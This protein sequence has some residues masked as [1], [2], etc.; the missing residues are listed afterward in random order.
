MHPTFT[1]ERARH[2]RGLTR[3]RRAILRRRLVAQPPRVNVATRMPP[4]VVRRSRV[5][6][7]AAP[8]SRRSWPIEAEFVR[9][10]VLITVAVWFILVALPAMIEL[11]AAGV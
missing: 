2:A 7:R 1:R 6:S 4:R 9:A 5:M 8:V 10:L 3:P 11:A